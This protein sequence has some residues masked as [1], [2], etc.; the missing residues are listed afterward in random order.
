MRPAR[1]RRRSNEAD[2]TGAF[3]QGAS[4]GRRSCVA[5]RMERKA[6][7]VALDHLS[8]V[9]SSVGRAVRDAA[10]SARKDLQHADLSPRASGWAAVKLDGTQALARLEAIA[11]GWRADSTALTQQ[12][13]LVRRLAAEAAKTSKV[14]T[15][16]S[17]AKAPTAVAASAA[18]ASAAASAL[19]KKVADTFYTVRKGDTLSAIAAR[20]GLSWKELAA[21]NSLKDPNKLAIGQRLRIPG[22]ARTTPPLP[23]PK[24]VVKPKPKPV[25]KPAPVPVGRVV[26]P[27]V[28][29]PK[30]PAPKPVPK[31]APKPAPKP[32]T[33]SGRTFPLSYGV[34]VFKQNDPAWGA[35]MLATKSIGAKGCA[36]TSTA[37]VLS[38]LSGRI[39]TPA[40][41]DA[42]LDKSRGYSGNSIVWSVAARYVGTTYSG[43]EQLSLSSLDR[44]LA[45]GKPVVISVAYSANSNARDHW[46]AVTAK[47]A[48]RG[49]TVYYANDPASGRPMTLTVRNGKLVGTGHRAFYSS[50]AMRFF[51][52]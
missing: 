49:T 9:H 25:V 15:S 33:G 48:E 45:A 36:V 3:S 32:I 16:V 30:K 38:K 7:A 13:S 42:Y 1:R 39:V 34:P 27:V 47:A 8:S 24:P 11:D 6:D 43:T 50:G 37:M 26:R 10:V 29:A 14:S 35:R 4:R 41:L 2:P 12:A 46:I 51:G 40:E 31:P 44:R 19:T 17:V 22:A 52:G 5:W 18:K 23:V 28:P 20:Y 21:Y